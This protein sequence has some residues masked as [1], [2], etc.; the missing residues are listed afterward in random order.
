MTNMYYSKLINYAESYLRVL[1][2]FAFMFLILIAILRILR[3]RYLKK[4]KLIGLEITPPSSIIKSPASNE[5]LFSVLHGMSLGRN[6]YEKLFG[7]RTT[8]SFEITSS[9]SKGIR[10]LVWVSKSQVQSI[11]KII[12]AYIPN[13][14]VT[15][16]NSLPNRK[17]KIVEFKQ[18]AH[19]A[20]PISG[21]K[22]SEKNDPLSYVASAMTKLKDNEEIILQMVAQPILVS[23]AKQLANS[24][25][26]LRKVSG[27][28]V[29]NT[30]LLVISKF[31]SSITD[32]ISFLTSSSS[33]SKVNTNRQ[34]FYEYSGIE[35]GVDSF[36]LDN[37]Q[38]IAR[39]M[40]SPLFKVNLR[41]LIQS[42]DHSMHLADIR[43][44]LSGYS[45]SSKQSF[46]TTKKLPFIG[47]IN[48]NLAMLRLPS[49]YLKAPI[50]SALELSS[51]FHFPATNVSRTDNL[52][53]S[54]SRSLAAPISLKNGT[55][56]DVLIGENHHR[57]E[58]TPIG[59]TEAERQKHMYI[60]G[61]TGNGK[62]T[63]LKYQII[64]DIE[65]GK[66]L[67]LI[68][69]HGDLAEEILGYIPKS[70]ANDVVYI[71]PDDISHPVAINLLEID[72]DIWGDDLL[73]EKDQITESVV[74]VLRKSFSDNDSGGHRI[75]YIL[76][77]TIQ[78]ALT[79]D[80]PTIFTI[81]RLLNDPK[82][83]KP[84]INNLEDH[85]LKMFWR[86]EIGKAGEMQR[87]KMSAGITS[88]IGRFLFS[89]S[90]RRM[91]EQESSSINFE[92]LMEEGKIIICNLS[93]G[94]IGEDTSALI[95]TT[96]LAK[97]QLAALKRAKQLS[98]NRQPFYLYVDEFQ[99]FA[100]MSF[101]QMLSEARKYKL[102][103]TMAEQSISQQDRKQLVDI[104]LA[105]VGTVVCFRTGS[106]LDEQYLL[107]IFSPYIDIGEISN[108]PS[109]NFYAKIAAIEPQEPVSGKTVIIPIE[110]NREIANLVI[111]NSRK[112]FAKKHQESLVKVE[113]EKGN[114]STKI[115]KNTKNN[116]EISKITV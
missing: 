58:I 7:I 32:F 92:K 3:Y 94:K 16:I 111:L 89:A 9:K 43:S 19:Y 34:P 101:V 81:F 22:E 28:T 48:R 76:R 83:R 97:L 49:L 53:S 74:S 70:R 66:G 77:N 41:A 104:I 2:L 37:M 46:K 75:E 1:L 42:H 62:S 96:I 20:Q 13:S 115:L 54:H 59:L 18:S 38:A 108:L 79:M 21:F 51:L 90:A 102:F 50:L 72:K 14:K 47:K 73:R 99:N 91:L 11:Q 100:T 15:L 109:Y 30:P 10:Y 65:A 61:G 87:V 55:K 85:D 39:K 8:I 26:F 27:H 95:G 56:L 113:T 23:G 35:N 60:V 44:A 64:Q 68:D 36:E 29:S 71:N 4:R 57:E 69:P 106:P 31:F 93:K 24:T 112:N 88:K 12:A 98:E 114:L 82:F 80:S 40:S 45:I 84:V 67:A 6:F 17:Y 103:L 25:Q 107:P 105:N 63:M 5:H 86:T 52:I 33:Y 116:Q 78:T 110:P